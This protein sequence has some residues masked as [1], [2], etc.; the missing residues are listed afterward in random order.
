MTQIAPPPI[1]DFLV[2]NEGKANLSWILF[3]NQLYEGDT[4][5]SWTPTFTSLTE[6]GGSAT[7]TGRYYRVNRRLCFFWVKIVPVTNT[8]ATAGTTYINN[9][10]LTA[11]NDGACWAVSGN[12]GDGPGHIVASNNRIYVPGWTTVTVP[13]YVVGFTEVSP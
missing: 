9:F 3:F 2:D 12:L 11:S 8:S 13:L 7:I 6:V 1:N 5:T 4:G 10:P